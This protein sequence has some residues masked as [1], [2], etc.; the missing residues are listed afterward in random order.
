[1][2]AAR[3]FRNVDDQWQP[4]GE[5]LPIWDHVPPRPNQPINVWVVPSGEGYQAGDVVVFGELGHRLLSLVP[6]DDEAWSQVVNAALAVHPPNH[7]REW[8]AGIELWVG[9]KLSG[10]WQ[11]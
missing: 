4:V 7:V 8:A 6:H 1:M 2:T 3:V 9:V 5:P 11:R 10:S